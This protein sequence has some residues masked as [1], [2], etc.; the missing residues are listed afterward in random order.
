MTYGLRRTSSRRA[1]GRSNREK[2][3]IFRI[4]PWGTCLATDPLRL[5]RPGL[6]PSSMF[7]PFS[8]TLTL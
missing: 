1:R 3:L 8:N 5:P 6:A 2:F 7:L 4:R